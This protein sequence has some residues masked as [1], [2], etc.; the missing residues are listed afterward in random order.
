VNT[1]INGVAI[2][3]KGCA[4]YCLDGYSTING[5]VQVKFSFNWL[6]FY[7]N[8][9]IF[10]KVTFSCCTT[11]LCNSY[12]N[13]LFSNNSNKS[14]FLYKSKLVCL[15]YFFLNIFSKYF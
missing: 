6:K 11:N 2:L 15:V 10:F 7:L 12:T 5:P 9:K 8:K 4:Q 14:I 3:T 1:T 13:S